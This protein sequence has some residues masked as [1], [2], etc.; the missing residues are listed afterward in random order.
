MMTLLSL[1]S[2]LAL[3]LASIGVY[4]VI[5]YS[6]SQRTR[7]IGMRMAIGASPSDILRLV[8]SEGLRLVLV[9]AALGIAGAFFLTRLLAT[10]L[11]GVTATDPWIFAAVTVVLVAVSLAAC[12]LPAA[13]PCA[14]TPSS[15]SARSNPR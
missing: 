3:L 7:E 13:A 11:Y 10:M 6:V 1:F 14:L 9:G 4:G 15:P 12:Y 8:L 5:S 2:G